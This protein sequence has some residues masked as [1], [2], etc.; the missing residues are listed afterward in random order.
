MGACA[1]HARTRSSNVFQQQQQQQDENTTA[2]ILIKQ[3]QSRGIHIQFLVI[4]ITFTNFLIIFTH[5]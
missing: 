1:E 2:K 3:A 5:I 4:T